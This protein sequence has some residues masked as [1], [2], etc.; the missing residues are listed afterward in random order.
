MSGWPLIL[1]IV[2]AAG[3]VIALRL[4]IRFIY[5][6]LDR[7]EHP[8]LFADVWAPLAIVVPF[9]FLTGAVGSS[10]SEGGWGPIGGPIW[11]GL[12]AIGSAMIVSRDAATPGAAPAVRLWITCAVTGV[13]LLL[14]GAAHELTVWAGQCTFA[15]AAVLLWVNTPAV[16]SGAAKARP[17]SNQRREMVAGLAMLFAL[18]AAVVQ[19]V[20]GL[21]IARGA[22]SEAAATGG[23]AVDAWLDPIQARAI[24]EAMMV[25]YG[26]AAVAGA[27]RAAGPA[28]AMRIGGWAAAIGPLF[29]IGLM[30]LIHLMPRAVRIIVGAE[31]QVSDAVAFG[32][33]AFAFEG[34]TLMLLP[35]LGWWS[36]RLP[37][38]GRILVGIAVIGLGAALAT[39]RV[40][41]R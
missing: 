39:W 19:G 33:G 36:T 11:C 38:R 7:I 35:L 1:L 18:L 29:A 26:G 16:A 30:S 8:E 14:L 12:A 17:K 3:A 25:A 6:A 2:Q 15:A 23:E 41:V 21:I 4:L 31:V 28:W 13:V 27:A 22:M 20:A 34:T 9:L 37:A 24:S 5:P 32:F 40:T 10:V